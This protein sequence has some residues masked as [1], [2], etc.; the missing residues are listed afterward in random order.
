MV[1]PTR[2]L[3]RCRLYYAVHAGDEAKP[4]S[5]SHDHKDITILWQQLIRPNDRDSL[6]LHRDAMT[7]WVGRLKETPFVSFIQIQQIRM[8]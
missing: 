3:M 8:R 2:A 6:G 1:A 7:D 5:N 4:T